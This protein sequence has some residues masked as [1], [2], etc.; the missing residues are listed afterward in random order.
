MIM[1]VSKSKKGKSIKSEKLR[2]ISITL[3]WLEKA[4]DGRNL[5]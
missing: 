2:R 1:N 4:F 3:R 5:T